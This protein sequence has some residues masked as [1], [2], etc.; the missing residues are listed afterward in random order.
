MEPPTS[1]ATSSRKPALQ[2][3]PLITSTC[4]TGERLAFCGT[5]SNVA[6][7]ASS[8]T[9][10]AQETTLPEEPED[11]GTILSAARWSN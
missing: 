5:S 4:E 10:G 11:L 2:T 1:A 8:T 6:E 7:L 9:W 3:N